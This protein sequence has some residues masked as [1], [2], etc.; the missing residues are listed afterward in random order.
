MRT[1]NILLVDDDPDLLEALSDLLDL[2][3]HRVSRVCDADRAL[4]LIDRM[5]PGP[6]VILVDCK[7][8]SMDGLDF[9]SVLRSRAG[10]ESTIPVFAASGEAAHRERAARVGATGFFEKPIELAALLDAIHAA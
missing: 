4:M 10:R 9:I 1:K 5:D 8:P 2:E 6:D 3:G 7:L